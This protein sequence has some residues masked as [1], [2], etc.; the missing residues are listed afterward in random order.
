MSNT[1][2]RANTDT[3]MVNQWLPS[4]TE[5][6]ANDEVFLDH[7]QRE[8]RRFRVVSSKGKNVDVFL[9]RAKVLSIGDQL[10]SDCGQYLSIVGAEEPV[11]TASTDNWQLFSR[12]CYHL[13]NRHVRLQ[14]GEQWLRITPDHV[15]EALLQRL[16]L[17][18]NQENAIFN[19]EAGAYDTGQKEQGSHGHHH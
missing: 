4:N 9:E 12:A 7:A 1:E 5:H 11:I 14:V 19:P 18:V 16:G 3:L 13:G 15:L 8:K 6:P 2:N 17:T 10:L